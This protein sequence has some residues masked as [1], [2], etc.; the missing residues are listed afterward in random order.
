MNMEFMRKCI[1]WEQKIEKKCCNEDYEMSK[2]LFE[3]MG[4]TYREDIFI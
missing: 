3:Q 4:G 2:N 1:F